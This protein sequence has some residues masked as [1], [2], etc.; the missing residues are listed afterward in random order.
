MIE[1]AQRACAVSLGQVRCC[2]QAS[3]SECFTSANK[4][5]P[6]TLDEQSLFQIPRGSKS[7]AHGWKS[8]F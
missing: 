4:R 3:V 2:L 1:V 7:H 5:N 8:I 6:D